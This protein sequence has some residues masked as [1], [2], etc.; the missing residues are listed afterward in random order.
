[1]DEPAAKSEHH[2]Q[3]SRLRDDEHTV[4]IWIENLQTGDES[5]ARNLWERYSTRLAGLARRHLL[6]V[7]RG[8]FDEE[9]VALSAVNTFL[10]GAAA[11]RFAIL[12]DRNDLWKLLVTITAGKARDY[13]RRELALKRGG[14]KVHALGDGVVEVLGDEPSPQLA[15]EFADTCRRLLESLEPELREVALLR[16]EGFTNAEIAAKIGRDV[17]TVERRLKRIR[18]Q[19]EHLVEPEHDETYVPE[20]ENDADLTTT[21]PSCPP[22]FAAMQPIGRGGMGEVYQ[23]QQ[24]LPKRTVALKFISSKLANDPAARARF[25]SEANLAAMLN[26]P[27]IVPVYQ[28]G[29][30]E[31]RPFL[32]MQYVDGG[33]LKDAI[34]ERGRYTPKRAATL[35]IRICRAMSY[36]HRLNVLHRDLKPANIL[37][38]TNGE[39]KIADF[40]LAKVVDSNM[41]W[42]E[43]GKIVGSPSYMS[44]EQA[45]GIDVQETTDVYSLGATL[46]HLLTGEPPEVLQHVRETRP[47]PPSEVAKQ[48]V[49]QSL[50]A[51]CLRCLEKDPVKRY[52][53]V[54]GLADDLERFLRGEPPEGTGNP[55]PGPVHDGVVYG[56]A[57]R[58]GGTVLASSGHDRRIHL[59]DVDDSTDST[60]CQ[61]LDDFHDELY[62]IAFSPDGRKLAAASQE[63][64]VHV[65]DLDTG[66]HQPLKGHEDVVVCVAWNCDGSRLASAGDDKIIRLWNPETGAMT[67]TLTGHSDFVNNIVFH[68]DEPN[69]LA[70]TGCDATLRFWKVAEEVETARYVGHTAPVW[71]LA[72]SPDGRFLATG[73]EDQ[74]VCIWERATSDLLHVC[75]GHRGTIWSV[76]FTNDNRLVSGGDDTSIRVWDAATGVETHRLRSHTDTVRCVATSENGKW[77]ASAGDD[78]SVVIWNAAALPAPETPVVRNLGGH[79]GPVKGVAVSPGGL[80][81]TGGND[82]I[83]RVWNAD[84]ESPRRFDENGHSALVTCLAFDG[85][86]FLASASGDNTIR[87]WNTDTGE[88]RELDGHRDRVYAVAFSPDG[89]R[90]ASA[91]WDA[92]VRIWDV[93]T[94]TEA[95]PPLEGHEGWIWCVAFNPDGSLL[96]S[97]GT[98][99]TVR[100]W[101]TNEG[102]LAGTIDGHHLKV[103]SVAFSPDGQRLASASADRTVRIWNP[104]TGDELQE[105][106]QHDERVYSVAFSPCGTMLASA[107][108][109]NRVTIWDAHTGDELRTLRGHAAAVNSICFTPDAGHLL[110]ASD[111]GTVRLWRLDGATRR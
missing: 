65:W 31:D 43:R 26:H 86:S 21:S 110:T 34:D 5:A 60:V 19:W 20:A 10:D 24:I 102:T 15:A 66:D 17:S 73:S 14:G 38:D 71:G 46:Y 99:S 1:M 76:A 51:I 55:R 81:A 63:C 13:R 18:Q 27:D 107:G 32:C 6:S 111:D 93:A 97:G 94:A 100:I 47:C 8:A 29:T 78:R 56:V 9:D 91:G 77:I 37:L 75:R 67:G 48:H 104:H 41:P 22:G 28:Y 108:D 2:S 62:L 82:H 61:T 106:L 45:S 58:P 87:L 36:A 49:P 44:P 68:P 57:F 23:A 101:N 25:E 42:E 88:S 52:A 12:N 98:D 3:V 109:D 33:S 96:A 80:V 89:K 79:N 7:P 39:P 40:G 11:G 16:V 54:D 30:H 50:E 64:V 92:T 53:A 70:S 35:M 103:H 69:I 4:T 74:T 72:W 84:S 59:W 85:D 90:L 95:M 83:V 105:P